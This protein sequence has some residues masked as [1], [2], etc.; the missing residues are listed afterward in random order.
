MSKYDWFII[1]VCIIGASAMLI[2]SFIAYK[3]YAGLLRCRCYGKMI[4]RGLEE[5]FKQEI[6]VLVDAIKQIIPNFPSV[7]DF[8]PRSK[9]QFMDR[10]RNVYYCW[11]CLDYHYIDERPAHMCYI[12]KRPVCNVIHLQVFNRPEEYVCEH[13]LR[14]K[15]C[16][17]LME[18]DDEL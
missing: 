9:V 10:N 1:I 16:Y 17:G 11:T 2:I 18:V 8:Q 4:V 5:G 12:C 13:C 15:V 6:P 7:Y 3:K 14:D